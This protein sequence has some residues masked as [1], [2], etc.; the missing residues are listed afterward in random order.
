MICIWCFVD[1]LYFVEWILFFWFVKGI[2]KDMFLIGVFF[3]LL[4]G[5][6]DIELDFLNKIIDM[7]KYMNKLDKM[8]RSWKIWVGKFKL[9][10]GVIYIIL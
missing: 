10:L 3:L 4:C 1:W 2:F 7:Y 9:L 5:L 8:V 6:Y